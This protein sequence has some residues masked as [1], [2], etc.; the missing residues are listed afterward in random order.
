MEGSISLMRAPTPTC[1]LLNAEAPSNVAPRQ[2]YR[3]MF[4]R[5]RTSVVARKMDAPSQLSRAYRPRTVSSTSKF[6]VVVRRQIHSCSTLE[7][8][9]VSSAIIEK[10][11]RSCTLATNL[12][13]T[14]FPI[15]LIISPCMWAEVQ[16]VFRL[17]QLQR[18]TESS[19]LKSSS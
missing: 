10:Y 8:S 13:T 1:S 2:F 5:R 15:K 9:A 4:S 12:L 14:S 18:S 17:S 19:V 16:V 7:T 3:G 6:S 11:L